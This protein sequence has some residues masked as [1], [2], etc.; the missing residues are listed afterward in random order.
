[1]TYKTYQILD[2]EVCKE[3]DADFWRKE[4]RLL[5]DAINEAAA[6]SDYKAVHMLTQRALNS[7]WGDVWYDIASTRNIIG[8]AHFDCYT[9][10]M[11]H[12]NVIPKNVVCYSEYPDVQAEQ[13]RHRNCGIPDNS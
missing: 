1:M 6:A 9:C 10:F 3:F 8:N 4:R 12:Q 5:N 13:M 11:K 7:G 2:A